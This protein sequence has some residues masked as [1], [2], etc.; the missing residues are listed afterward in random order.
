MAQEPNLEKLLVAIICWLLLH[1]VSGVAPKDPCSDEFHI[2][3]VTSGALHHQ[4]GTSHQHS[5]LDCNMR[6]G[7][8]MARSRYFTNFALKY[9]KEICWDSVF[10]FQKIKLK[11]S[12]DVILRYS[13][14]SLILLL[15][16]GQHLYRDDQQVTVG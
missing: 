15:G 11:Y 14:S 3:C 4:H 6:Y 5:H 7:D 1:I 12:Y 9:S 10:Y 16:M 2:D 13:C 8:C